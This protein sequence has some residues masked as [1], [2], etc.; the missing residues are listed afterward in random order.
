MD[1]IVIDVAATAV[2][3]VIAATVIGAIVIVTVVIAT[4]IAGAG[5]SECWPVYMA[6]RY[7]SHNPCDGYI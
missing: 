6:G 7:I 1:V 2:T 4:D 3:V 5:K